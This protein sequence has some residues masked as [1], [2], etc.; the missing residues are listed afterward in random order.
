MRASLARWGNSLAVRVPRELAESLGLRE[1][2]ALDLTIE[3]NAIIVRRKR[4]DIR[5]LVA[6]MDADTIPPLLIDDAP[7]GT[8]EW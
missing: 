7:R 6:A 1:G 3:D 5:E 4:Y 8:E 2:A